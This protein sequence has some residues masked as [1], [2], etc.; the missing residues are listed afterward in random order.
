MAP[1]VLSAQTLNRALLARQL[2]LR[3]SRLPIPRALERIGGLQTQYAPSGYVGLWSRLEGLQRHALTR[4]LEQRRVIQGTLLRSTIHM[5]SAA[6]YSPFASAIRSARR[7]W[8]T[9]IVRQRRLEVDM[10]AAARVVAA[11]LDDGPRPRA[12]LIEALRAAGFDEPAW[13]GVSA[14]LDMVRVP[15]SGTWE[16]RRAD[17]YGLA[18]TWVDIVEVP[19]GVAI[20][21]LMRSYLG[22]FGPASAADFASW[23]G[24]PMD[25][26]RGAAEVVA[27]RR[28]RDERG[29]EL[30][31]VPRA[32]IPDAETPAPVR[33]LPTWDAT[34]LVHARRTQ[35][36]PEDLRSLIF[37][38][39]NPHSV[40]TV[41]VDGSVAATWRFDGARV[42]V[43]SLVPLP[44][45]ARREVEA[46]ADALTAFHAG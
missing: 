19:E 30:L 7:S 17:R 10:T 3:R 20:Q 8:W 42:V 23:A 13:E 38:T 45:R 2:L 32:P 27:L 46:E 31:D 26:V 14:W 33:M 29:G 35:I 1:R 25:A 4:A 22:G 24:L 43:E 5:V 16:R 21:H 39:K 44:L 15:P 34:L 41:L 28:F 40:G 6:D 36:L 9:G 12:E 18:A 11:A 37:H